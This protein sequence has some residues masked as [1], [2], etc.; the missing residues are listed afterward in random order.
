MTGKTYIRITILENMIN[1]LDL[2]GFDKIISGKY[3]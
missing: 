2:R 3:E 1:C